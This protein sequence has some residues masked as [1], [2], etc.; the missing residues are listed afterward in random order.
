MGLD[1]LPY[2][3]PFKAGLRKQAGSPV[4]YIQLPALGNDAASWLDWAW[5][6]PISSHDS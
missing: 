3:Q 1:N 6:I 5:G 4:E 2:V